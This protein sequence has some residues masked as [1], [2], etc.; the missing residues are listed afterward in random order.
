REGFV[1]AVGSLEPRKN[2]KAL[3]AVFSKMKQIR[4]LVVGEKNR[5][6]SEFLNSVDIPDNI[7]FTGRVSDETLV[8]FYNKASLFV[9]PSLSEG[10]GIPPL[11]AQACGCPVLV[12]KVTSLPEACGDSAI[13]CD[14]ANVD[15][16]LKKIETILANPKIQ[17]DLREKGF[18]NV[19]RF[20]WQRSAIGLINVLEK[21]I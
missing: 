20:S 9:Y 12:S 13:Y 8:E 10:F 17:R 21:N 15:D 5:V 6:F 14:P 18:K 11:E 19:Q 16:I 4:L 2:L 1:L 3:M 7:E